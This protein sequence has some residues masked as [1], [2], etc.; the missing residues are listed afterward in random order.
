MRQGPPRPRAPIVTTDPAL[1][2]ALARSSARH[3][4]LCPRQVLGARMAIAGARQLGLD[5]PRRDKRLIAIVET[6][7]C[8]VDGVAAASGC[9]VGART[10]RVEDQG[11]VAATFVDAVSG[12]A[13]RLRPAAGARDAARDW[14]SAASADANGAVGQAQA[15]GR[16]AA[17]LVGYQQMPDALLLEAVQVDLI[18]PIAEVLSHPAARAICALCGEEIGNGREVGA[19]EPALCVACAGGGYWRARVR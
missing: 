4:H 3:A 2:A 19:G 16:W 15:A 9:R 5:L 10:L 1:A 14:T 12:T 7:G 6:D 13:W 11:K 8:F 18:R 17:Y